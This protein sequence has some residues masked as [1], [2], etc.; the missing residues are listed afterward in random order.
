MKQIA[1]C[2]ALIFL[3]CCS[4]AAFAG[5]S[6]E[7]VTILSFQ[8]INET[9]YV[10]VVAPSGTDADWFIKGCKTFVVLGTY[11]N[12]EGQWPLFE[13]SQV[14]LNEHLT[15]VRFIEE[16]S[17]T[18]KELDLGFM[19]G[20]FKPVSTNNKCV[21]NSRALQKSQNSILSYYHKV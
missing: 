20:G 7:K 5:G 17:K 10:L 13:K 9:D 12:L 6:S 2:I 1:F 18:D 21:V 4:P 15:S 8:K 11:A 3:L 14:T 16:K 19:G